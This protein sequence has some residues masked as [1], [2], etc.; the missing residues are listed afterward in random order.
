MPNEATLK[1]TWPA[2][3]SMEQRFVIAVT[4]LQSPQ[5][6]DEWRKLLPEVNWSQLLEVTRPDLYPYLHFC[7]QTRVGVGFCPQKVMWQLA[8][9]RQVTA[10]RNLRRLAELRAIQTALAA[11]NIP[12]I[13]LTRIMLA[14]LAYHDPSLR[15][16]HDMDSSL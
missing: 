1:P 6:E 13:A 2:G 7:M 12:I 11:Q 14:F 8:S 9:S 4:G 5:R 3:S 15:P 10:L 16:M